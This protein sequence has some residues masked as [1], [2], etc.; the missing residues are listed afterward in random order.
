MWTT[1]PG[2]YS[3]QCLCVPTIG[4]PFLIVRG[5]EAANARANTYLDEIVGYEDGVNGVETLSE[6]LKRRDWQGKR[7]ALDR[8]SWFLSIDQYNALAAFIGEPCD[9]SGIVEL[10]RSI[11]SPIELQQIERA[12]EAAEAGMRAAI[13]EID[14][15]A[16]ENDVAAAMVSAAY[17]NG[18]EYVGSEPFVCSGPRSG[19]RHATWR[20]RV[21]KEGDL[22]T[23][24]NSACFNRY[25]SALFRTAC[26]GRKAEKRARLMRDVCIEGLDI[27]LSNLRPGKT[28]ADVHN[29]VQAFI[30]MHGYTDNYRKRTGYSIGIAFPPDWGEGNVLSLY[31]GVD[32]PLGP[33]MAFHIPISLCVHGMFTV[34]ASETAIVTEK[35]ARPLS[36]VERALF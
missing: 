33:G 2:Y 35:N 9:G 6:E 10:S 28:C 24:E 26:V 11:K 30:D 17:R 14:C 12:A 8:R 31:R 1:K 34:C 32:V 21:L 4:L 22:V 3:F 19:L 16:N 5:L 36:T 23:L 20:R 7:I 29:A 27:A 13:A 25:H 18:S 15:G